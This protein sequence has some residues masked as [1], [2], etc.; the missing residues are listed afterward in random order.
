MELMA[1]NE[2]AVIRLNLRFM[3]GRMENWIDGRMEEG[4]CP[5]RIAHTRLIV[6]AGSPGFK[7]FI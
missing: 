1:T 5:Q 2:A 4:E 7:V 3:K 6:A